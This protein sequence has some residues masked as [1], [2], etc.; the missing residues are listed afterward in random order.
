VVV[1][2]VFVL[3]NI[4]NPMYIEELK[5]MVPPPSQNSVG[6]C[7][8]INF[9]FHYYVISS[10]VT[11]LQI[12]DGHIQVTDGFDLTVSLNFINLSLP[13]FCS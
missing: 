13:F 12:T 4:N 3:P 8:Q 7:N 2:Y 6:V 10:L 5:E 11:H 9:L 1:L